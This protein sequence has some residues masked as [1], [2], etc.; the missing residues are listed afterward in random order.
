[1]V[2]EE[3]RN[4]D[5]CRNGALTWTIR[6][7]TRNCFHESRASQQYVHKSL[8]RGELFFDVSYSDVSRTVFVVI[9]NNRI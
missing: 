3:K 5:F 8:S 7:T 1:M 6:V 9:M 2:R 4:F